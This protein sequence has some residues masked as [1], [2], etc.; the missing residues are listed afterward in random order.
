MRAVS[1]RWPVIQ[2]TWNCAR[3]GA[4][5]SRS[6]AVEIEKSKNDDPVKQKL[7]ARPPTNEG[8]WQSENVFRGFKIL[9][10][11]NW[12]TAPNDLIQ[13]VLDV[14]FLYIIYLNIAS[15]I[16]YGSFSQ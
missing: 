4:Q 14:S 16:N 13:T 6:S 2:W 7:A 5:P 8:T 1:F 3:E 11:I 15:H 10:C 9:C 12:K